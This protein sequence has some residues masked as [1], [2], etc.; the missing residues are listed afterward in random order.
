MNITK[1]PDQGG[2]SCMV[3]GTF[4]PASTNST[5]TGE[6]IFSAAR[7]ARAALVHP[8]A[9]VAVLRVPRARLIMGSGRQARMMTASMVREFPV[10]RT[11]ASCLCGKQLSHPPAEARSAWKRLTHPSRQKS[12]YLWLLMQPGGV[13]QDNSSFSE[14]SVAGGTGSS[15]R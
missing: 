6:A 14:W 11:P 3:N 10:P 8:A 4:L 13:G 2:P 5:G 9:W 15:W 12:A 7:E 1:H